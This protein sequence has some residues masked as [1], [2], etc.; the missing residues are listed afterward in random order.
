MAICGSN[1][2]RNVHGL[3]WHSIVA[4]FI[5]FTRQMREKPASYVDHVLLSA[6]QMM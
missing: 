1:S 3:R 6:C 4:G 2:N 5:G